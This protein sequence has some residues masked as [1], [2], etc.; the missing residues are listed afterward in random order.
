MGEAN[1]QLRDGVAASL[2]K[3]RSLLERANRHD[4]PVVDTPSMINH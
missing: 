3:V 2:A 4:R 1:G